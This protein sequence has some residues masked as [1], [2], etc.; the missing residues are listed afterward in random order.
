[1]RASRRL[2]PTAEDLLKKLEYWV[3]GHGLGGAL[4]GPLGRHIEEEELCNSRKRM[5]LLLETEPQSR[6]PRRR[7]HIAQWITAPRHFALQ[8]VSRTYRW[9]YALLAGDL[10]LKNDMDPIIAG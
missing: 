8:A 6:G 4:E 5:I 2:M 7:M 10:P 1:M 9:Q 3:Q